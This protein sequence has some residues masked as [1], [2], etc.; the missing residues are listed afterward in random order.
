MLAH[1]F[2]WN[3]CFTL[4]LPALPREFAELSDPPAG[5]PYLYHQS[6]FTECRKQV[7]CARPI[8]LCVVSGIY[9][10]GVSCLSGIYAPGVFI[11]VIVM[12]GIYVRDKI[13]TN[14]RCIQVFFGFV[15]L[16]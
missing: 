3:F 4:I 15:C 11:L 6:V 13:I 7:R 1:V 12:F 5:L 14:E 16:T 8:F 10:P 2:L 9:A